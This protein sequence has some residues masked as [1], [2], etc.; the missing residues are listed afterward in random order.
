MLPATVS[1][2]IVLSSLISTWVLG[3]LHVSAQEAKIFGSFA[4]ARSVSMDPQ[5][6]ILVADAGANKIQRFNPDGELVTEIGGYGWGQLEFDQPYDVCASTGLDIFVADYGNHRIQRFNRKLEY[7]AT[8]Y[9]RDANDERQRFGYPGGVAV[10]RFGD[11]LLCD[12]ENH[13]ILKVSEFNRIERSIGGIDAGKGRVVDPRQVEVGLRDNIYV[14]ERRRI[15]VFDNF[16]NYI[17]TI[18]S[19]TLH[20]ASGF[21]VYE[22][23]IFVADSLRVLEIGFEGRVLNALPVSEIVPLGVPQECVDV[24]ASASRL[25]VLFPHNAVILSR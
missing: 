10:T 24:A 20:A 11:L 23:S 5:A 9:T 21:T 2:R 19:D 22:S 16:G 1:A 18:G 7:V 15:V 14:L 3:L 25:V 17:R 8:L 12:R 13:R 6:N 4:Q